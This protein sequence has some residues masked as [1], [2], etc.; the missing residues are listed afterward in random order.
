MN[1]VQNFKGD[2][3]E[4]KL[5]SVAMPAFNLTLNSLNDMFENA[6]NSE[7]FLLSLYDEGRMPYAQRVK[8]EVFVPFIRKALE[9]FPFVGTFD[10]YIFILREIFGADSD[11][12]FEISDPGKFSVSVN[13]SV[14][15]LFE[16]IAREH[17]NGVYTFFDLI[18]SDGDNLVY[19]GL[20]GIETEAELYLLFAEIMP[21]GIVPTI[22]LDFFLKS[23]FY[24]E[25]DSGEF[26]MLTSFNDNIIF[27]EVLGG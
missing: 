4:L 20:S 18:T 27:I 8:R 5:K 3:T 12:F 24:G 13:A 1:G 10:S 16:A 21:A 25:D 22:S 9:N 15:I 2:E 14:D 26:D 17:D 11:L 7:V 6:S 19:K 23:V